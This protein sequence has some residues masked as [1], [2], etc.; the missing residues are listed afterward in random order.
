MQKYIV[1]YAVWLVMVMIWNFGWPEATPVQDVIVAGILAVFSIGIL[2]NAL[3]RV[4]GAARNKN[5]HIARQQKA[6]EEG[7]QK[8]L[9]LFREKEEIRNDDV[10]KMLGVSD[11]T[12]TNY[13]EELEVEDKIYQVGRRGKYVVYREKH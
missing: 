13:L 9:K 4:W 6:K 5:P 1:T 7:K 12:A 2:H 11:A 10:E 8:I 3:G